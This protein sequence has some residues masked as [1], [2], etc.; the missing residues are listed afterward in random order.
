[1]QSRFHPELTPEL[2]KKLKD[3]IIFY[4]RPLKSQKGLISLCEFESRE[5]DISVDGVIKKKKIGPRV[6]PR[7]SPLFQEFKVYQ[8]VNNILVNGEPL[9]DNDREKLVGELAFREKMKW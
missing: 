5:V 9:D 6:C 8:T 2:K 4:Q 3:I 7:S 1:M